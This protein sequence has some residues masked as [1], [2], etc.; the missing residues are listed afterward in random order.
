MTIEELFRTAKCEA[1]A[2]MAEV[3]PLQIG[4]LNAK[5]SHKNGAEQRANACTYYPLHKQAGT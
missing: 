3:R 1:L 4:F 2:I 5:F